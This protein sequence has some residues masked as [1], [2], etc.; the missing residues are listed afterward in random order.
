MT[1]KMPELSVI[2]RIRYGTSASFLPQIFQK[3]NCNILQVTVKMAKFAVH[4][5]INMQLKCSNI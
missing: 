3:M 1:Y 5:N 4:A 2:Q